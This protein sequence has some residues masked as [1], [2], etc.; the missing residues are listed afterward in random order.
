MREPNRSELTQGTPTHPQCVTS[1]ALSNAPGYGKIS[2]MK[3]RDSL[4]K[5]IVRHVNRKSW[6]HVPPQDPEAYTK[7]GKF[8]A[9]SFAEAEFWGRPLD[10]P[11]R[12]TISHPL[13]GDEA[14]VEEFLLGHRVS[15]NEISIE[16]RFA[17][18]ARLKRMAERRGY[19][20]IVIM[21]PRAFAGFKSNG[22]LPR[23][24][25]LNTFNTD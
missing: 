8:L 19:D 23:S 2:P 6:W 25:E 16:N 11:Q 24:L 10:E 17:L 12:V 13:V 18:D 1:D 22:K 15:G 21:S 9:S 3:L 20:S 4:V 5:K 7:R 14:T